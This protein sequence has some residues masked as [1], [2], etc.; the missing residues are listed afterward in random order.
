[1]VARKTEVFLLRNLLIGWMVSIAVNFIKRE[2]RL[3]IAS[4]LTG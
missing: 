2:K 4:D 1:M 3:P